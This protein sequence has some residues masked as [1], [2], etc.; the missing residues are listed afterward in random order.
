MILRNRS[1]TP[2]VSHRSRSYQYFPATG[3]NPLTGYVH[4]TDW[5]P[6]SSVVRS[7]DVTELAPDGYRRVFLI[8]KRVDTTTTGK[9]TLNQHYKCGV[10][11]V[12]GVPGFCTCDAGQRGQE[13]THATALADVID[14]GAIPDPRDH[15]WDRAEPG[16]LDQFPC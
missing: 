8:V 11:T 14:T 6:R 10:P 2:P 7:Y 3:D 15:D 12:E 13:C 9:R 1:L 16:Y 5:N 4:V